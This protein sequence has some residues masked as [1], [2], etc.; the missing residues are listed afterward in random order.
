MRNI[1]ALLLTFAAQVIFAREFHVSVK[2][3]GHG[4]GTATNPFPTISA[5]A[6]VAQ[7]GDVIT[8]HEGVYRERVNPPR[9]GVSERK[10]I[11][12]QAAPGERVEIKGSEVVTH[13]IQV[14]DDVWQVTLPSSFFG[15]FNPYNDLIHGDWFKDKGR[16]HHTGAVYLNGEWLVEAAKLEDVLKPVETNTLWFAEVDDKNTK[17]WAQFKGVNPNEQLVEINVRQTVFYPAQTG[18]NFITVRGF[19]LRHAATP[20]APPTAEQIGLIGTHWSKGWIIESNI[21]SHSICTGITLG[22]YGDEFDNTSADTAEGYVK[23]IE[24]AH[25]QAIPWTKEN[26]GHHLVRNNDI[27]HCEQGGIVGSLGGA[28][29]TITGN[30]IHEIHVR[31]LFTG[32]EMAGIKL[33][34]AIDTEISRNH[35]YRTCRGIWLD[36]MAQGTRVTRNLLRDNITREDLFVEVNHGPFLVDN[37]LFLSPR[38]LLVNSQGGAYVHNLMVGTVRIIHTERRETPYHPPHSTIVAGLHG[39]PSG[40]DRY[41]NNLMAQ[42]TSLTSY[43]AAVMPVF[44]SGNVFVGGAKPSKHEL[45]PVVAADFDPGVKLVEDADG[46]QLEIKFDKTWATTQPRKLVTTELLGK[47]KIPNLPYE[48]ANSSSL[49]VNTDYFGKR[50][51]ETNPTPGPFENPG[52][53]ALKLKVW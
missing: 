51:S 12:Y 42:Q 14:Q 21:I 2:G 17:I 43:D 39:N 15:S 37:N 18:I 49:K 27:S 6:Q 48:N 8:V 29:S 25:A 30:S 47:A 4:D 45:S 53:G 40:D 46:F 26:I 32:A 24:R 33:H 11:V 34:G 28:F 41:Y 7:P 5:A 16:K 23:T 9:G 20:W 10:R 38:A 19:I 31:Q 1:I 22:K 44:M 3:D 35:I 36:W 50:R 52:E 13:W